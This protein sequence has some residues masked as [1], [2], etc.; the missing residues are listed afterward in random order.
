[1]MHRTVSFFSPLFLQNT[2]W[3]RGYK[4]GATSEPPNSLSSRKIFLRRSDDLSFW[5][6]AFFPKEQRGGG[7]GGRKDVDLWMK[8]T[9]T[10]TLW[11]RKKKE[12]H[13]HWHRQSRAKAVYRGDDGPHHEPCSSREK[14][15]TV[16]GSSGKQINARAAA[17]VFKPNY[18]RSPVMTRCLCFFFFFCSLSLS[19]KHRGVSNENWVRY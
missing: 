10:R 4:I 1:M 12:F 5:L 3:V 8:H 14:I 17:S 15:S 2:I 9:H 16:R 7:E 18:H 19:S 13:A 6:S 11:E